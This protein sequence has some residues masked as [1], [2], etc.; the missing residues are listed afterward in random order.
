MRR[1]RVVHVATIDLTL[2]VLLLPQLR[3]LRDE[4]F[5]V[6]AISSPGPSVAALEAEGIRHIPW[7]HVT[8][9]WKPSSDARAFAELYRI[10]SRGRFD[11]VH[12]HNPKPGFMG[13]IAGHLAGTPVIVNTVHGLWASPDDRALRK[14]PVIAAEWLA[15]RFSDRELYQS[16][17][18][19]GWARRLRLV[20]GRKG[21]LLGNGTDTARFAP[22]AVPSRRVLALRR[23]LGIGDDAIVV[24][25]VGRLVAEKGYRELFEAAR[26]LRS[27]DPR[28]V[29]L[30]VGGP[31]PDKPDALSEHELQAPSGT[32]IFAGWRDDVRDLLAAMDVFVLASWREGLP[33]SA[34]EA[35]AMGKPM[36]LSSIRGCREVVRDGIE[37]FL[38]P[39]RDPTALTAAIERLTDDRELRERMGAAARRRAVERFDEARVADRLLDCYRELLDGRVRTASEEEPPAPASHTRRGNQP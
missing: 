30:V 25:C 14:V 26:R 35:A 9:A 27:R 39:R 8:R 13:R 4:G 10:L 36:V 32:V 37:G 11:I 22:G 12:T 15:A 20:D 28:V 21:R 2:R 31:D 18:D 24:G 6:T 38:V 19:L 7:V 3:R 29:L 16:E 34:V 5:E 23:E 33:R 1:V 17:E